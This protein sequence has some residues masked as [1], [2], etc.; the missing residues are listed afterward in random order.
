M[1]VAC[2]V[3]DKRCGT[4]EQVV[5]VPPEQGGHMDPAVLTIF[6]IA[7]LIVAAIATGMVRRRGRT[8]E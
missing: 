7:I 5:G 8:R 3:D 4:W 2:R 6:V 1:T